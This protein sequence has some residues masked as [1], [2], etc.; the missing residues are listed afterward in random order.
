MP[1]RFGY[2][3]SNRGDYMHNKMLLHT[4]FRAARSCGSTIS[5]LPFPKQLREAKISF[6]QLFTELLRC[7]TPSRRRFTE[8]REIFTPFKN[9]FTAFR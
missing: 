5:P 1:S 9:R 8:L 2:T 4:F 7:Y 6:R 3:P